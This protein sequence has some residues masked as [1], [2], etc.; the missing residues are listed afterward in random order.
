MAFGTV[1]L[2]LPKIIFFPGTK[3]QCCG[4]V[5]ARDFRKM[6]HSE[7]DRGDKDNCGHMQ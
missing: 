7:A 6:R 4:E 2:L 3:E 1:F 5:G